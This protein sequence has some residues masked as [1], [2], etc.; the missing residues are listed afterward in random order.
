MESPAKKKILLVITKSN[1]G[2]AQKYVLDLASAL[3]K[4]RF[5]VA[6]AAGGSGPLLGE[7]GMAG[8][9]TIPISALKRDI[10]L[11]GDIR[12]LYALIQIMRDE[13]P[14]I[15]HVNSS[16]AGGFGAFAGRVAG[17]P[18]IIF[19]CHGWAF[20]EDRS[21]LSR[22]V[23]KFF[24][25]LTV[26]F[27]HTTIAVSARDLADGQRMPFAKSKVVLAH[28]GIRPP[29]LKDR[30]VARATL[31]AVA[32][33]SGIEMP[34]NSLLFGAIGELHK[35]KGYEFMLRAFA[36]AR[37]SRN[38]PY[39]LLVMGEGEER[40]KLKKL[41]KELDL[42]TD[43]ALLGY[44][45]DAPTYLKAFD[46]FAL[47]SV[48][49]GLPYV[50]IEAGYA[51]LPVVATNVGGVKEIIEDMRSGILV[52]ARKPEDIAEG[53]LMLAKEPEKV[54]A[55]GQNLKAKVEREFSIEKMVEKTI[56]VYERR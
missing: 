26:M 15:V 34:K 4:D 16:K 17:I 7:L 35:N 22:L 2:G 54:R 20:N 21:A 50:L 51:A 3:P 39:R 6:V 27:A 47:T 48:K 32:K 55:F 24:S 46:A 53:L 8:I 31:F 43:V 11:L 19:T 28:N 33:L 14:D 29:Q 38:F 18:R 36:L 56:A 23:I 10:A 1:L 45:K 44:V 42:E 41:M 49:E 37:K 25:W 5:D 52:Q 13:K 12:S 40:P 9:R 30:D